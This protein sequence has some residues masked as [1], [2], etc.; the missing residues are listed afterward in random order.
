MHDLITSTH[1]YYE[2]Y[3]CANGKE[4]QSAVLQNNFEAVI[5]D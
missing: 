4:N 5:V 1:L 3:W 2:L